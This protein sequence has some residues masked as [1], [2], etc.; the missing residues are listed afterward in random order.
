MNRRCRM[1]TAIC[2]E[3]KVEENKQAELVIYV[4]GIKSTTCPTCKSKYRVPEWSVGHSAH[5]N[6]CNTRF[7][8]AEYIHRSKGYY[9]HTDDEIL[10]WLN[11]GIDEDD[12]AARPRIMSDK[13]YKPVKPIRRVQSGAY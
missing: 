13:P 9:P 3:H 11:E 2:P 12:L 5:C 1:V 6:K 7:T 10:S 4:S 8:I